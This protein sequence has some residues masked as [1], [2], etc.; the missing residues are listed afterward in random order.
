MIDYAARRKKVQAALTEKEIDLL[1]VGPSENMTY[2][3]G[4]HTHADERPCLFMLS[5]NKNGFLMPALNA[6]DSKQ[7]TKLPM[8]TWADAAGPEKALAKL[9]EKLGFKEVK[10]VALDETMRTDFS[11][12]MLGHLP[13]RAKALVASDVLADSRMRKDAE[14]IKLLQMNSN[15]AD[16]AVQAAYS[17]I[18][19]GVTET[20]VANAA[21]ETFS[22]G[23]VDQVT[24][25]IVGAGKNGAFPHHHTGK[26]KLK[27]GDAIVI[28][29]GA[30]KN[31]YNSDITRM[32]FLGK[33]ST[34][35]LEVHQVVED[36]V[37][38]ALA[39]IKPGVLA[40]DIDKAARSVIKKAGYGKYFVHR[41]GHG[42]GLTGHELP[43]ITETS[44]FELD[45]GMVFSVEPGIYLPGKFGVRLEEIVTITRKGVRVFS[46]LPRDLYVVDV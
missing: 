35:Y 37:Q 5:P 42:L 27:K 34:K 8:A 7:K 30:R 25:T 3:L 10:K 29:I 18:Q 31:L 44:D 33:P 17:A 40:M 26:T 16:K 23:K 38:A 4:F 24:F 20:D 9:G 12:L 21:R 14:E 43:N 46:K 2:L 39:I 11:L 6:E 19:V 32:A 41:T 22:E 1:A 28:D 15:I 36:A 13:K 45:E